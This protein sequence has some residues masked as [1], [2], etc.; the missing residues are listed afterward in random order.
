MRDRIYKAFATVRAEEDW[1]A[2]T[3]AAVARKSRRRGRPLVWAAACCLLFVALGGGLFFT[4]VSAIS[5]DINPSLQLTVNLFD[6][7]IGVEAYNED[8]GELAQN[9]P[10]LFADYPQALRALLAAAPVKACLEKGESLSIFVVCD[11]EQRSQEM[12][13]TVEACAGQGRNVHCQSGG[14]AESAAAQEAGLSC[15]KYRAFLEWQALDPAVTPEDAQGLTMR[16][17]REKIAA[18]SGE[19]LPTPGNG[20]GHGQGN[21]QGNGQGQGHAQS[22]SSE[23]Y[24]V[25][26]ASPEPCDSPTSTPEQCDSQANGE[27]QA[28]GQGKGHGHGGGHGKGARAQKHSHG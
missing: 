10:L 4:P 20:Q 17:I 27:G 25:Q 21:G 18:L 14:W 26:S 11:D 23:P 6:R 28:N 7:V 2:R 16:E 24:D 9:T 12:L 1:K 3:M 8:A 19:P 13:A 22:S 15:G 5:V